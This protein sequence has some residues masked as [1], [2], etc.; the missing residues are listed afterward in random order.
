MAAYPKQLYTMHEKTFRT[1]SLS[2]GE[3][4]ATLFG[5]ATGV[6]A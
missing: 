6:V 4:Q 5:I 1:V 2:A 3:G